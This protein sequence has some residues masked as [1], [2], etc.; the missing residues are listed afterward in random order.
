VAHGGSTT[1][2]V[3]RQCEFIIGCIERM[4]E[5]GS[6]YIECRE[7][8]FR[9]YNDRLDRDMQRMVWV[10]DGVESRFL[11]NGGRVVST[12]PWRMM[13]FY[14]MTRAMNPADFC[15]QPTENG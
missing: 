7:E 4:L 2:V 6:R 10:Q 8:A 5:H 12:H 1:L 15:F 11:N 14:E 9:E 13:E 3:E